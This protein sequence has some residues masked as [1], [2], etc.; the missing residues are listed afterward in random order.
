MTFHLTYNSHISQNS[1]Q[2]LLCNFKKSLSEIIALCKT[3]INYSKDM[4]NGLVADKEHCY[5]PFP[6]TG[7][8]MA[9]LAGRDD[10]F[11]LG[12][13]STHL[14][15]EMESDVDIKRLE[16]AF[17]KLINYH[18]MLRVVVLPD[19]M[20]KILEEVPYYHIAVDD[21]CGLPQDQA[22]REFE[23]E[24]NRM[25]NAIFETGIWP[26]FEIKAVKINPSTYRIFMGFD[27]M[28]ADG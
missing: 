12:G 18:P 1:A 6:L 22:A 25:S 16:V 2:E 26:M 15:M 14:F 10:Q 27:L 20:Q 13:T 28:I 23:A 7:V 17:N 9:Y 8:Q 21:L 11:E 5:E 3:A 24:K 4:F 19:G